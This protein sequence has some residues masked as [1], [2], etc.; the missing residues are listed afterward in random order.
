MDIKFGN[1]DIKKHLNLIFEAERCSWSNTNPDLIID[2]QFLNTQKAKVEKLIQS[3]EQFAKIVK[4]NKYIIGIALF[5]TQK[6]RDKKFGF[7]YNIYIVSEYRN[8]GF[9]YQ[10]MKLIEQELKKISIQKI[11]LNVSA[12]N[13]PALKI[14]EKMGYSKTIYSMEKE[15]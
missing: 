5:G 14:Y 10:I 11:R 2:D 6:I 13:L 9:G 8:N 12:N 4:F 7:V 3:D 1:L 15:I